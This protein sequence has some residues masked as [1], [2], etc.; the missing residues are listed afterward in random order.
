MLVLYVSSVGVVGVLRVAYVVCGMC[1]VSCEFG[2]CGC[3]CVRASVLDVWRL[4]RV[5][6]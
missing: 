3:P 2:L 4:F 5:C 1:R 6:V